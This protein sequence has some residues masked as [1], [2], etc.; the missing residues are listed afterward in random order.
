M[1]KTTLV[2]RD[3]K[4]GEI[5]IKE[6]EKANINIH[7]ALWLFDSEADR[8]QLIVASNN[9]NFTSPK[10]AYGEIWE[11]LKQMEE[12]GLRIAF[13][14]ENISV[15][16]PN[17]QLINTLNQA[18]RTA[19]DDISD[20]RFSRIRIGSSYIEDAYIYRIQ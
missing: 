11:V 5:L 19:P 20:I 4:D 9:A 14:L 2:E 1:D 7:S 13:S 15:V 6:L 18:V 17:H 10:K 12:K 8:W 3:F 16:S